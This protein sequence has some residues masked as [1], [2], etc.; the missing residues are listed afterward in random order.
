VEASRA[1]PP[2]GKKRQPSKADVA[3]SHIRKLYRI[4]KNARD[5]SDSE[6]LRVRQEHSLPALKVFRTWLG[7]NVG[8]LMK[9][10]LTRKA[11]E[12]TLNQ[13]DTLVGYCGR[14]DL[15]ISNVL[16]ENAIRPFAVGRKAWLFA[17][18]S[19]GAQA[20]ATCYSL[21]ETAKANGLEPSAY[22]HHV[23]EHIAEADT[24]EKL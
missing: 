7:D 22:I 2:G 6:R 5:L 13:W 12:Y 21:I 15:Q 20:S 17:D 16:A 8:K 11:M 9:G 1:A 4:E 14:G 3:L 24:V 19:Q 10:S 23:L 18:T